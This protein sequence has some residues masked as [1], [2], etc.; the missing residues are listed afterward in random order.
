MTQDVYMTR[1]KAHTQ[2]AYL[3]DAAINDA[4]EPRLP[5]KSD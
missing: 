2:I 4:P 5:G 3:L 1:G